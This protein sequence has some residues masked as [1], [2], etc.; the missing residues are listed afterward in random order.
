M[1]NNLVLALYHSPVANIHIPFTCLQKELQNYFCRNCFVP[2]PLKNTPLKNTPFT[3]KDIFLT[4]M[5]HRQACKTAVA[6][7]F[8]SLKIQSGKD[9]L[10]SQAV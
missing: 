9:I 4:Y 7:L 3:T 1:F 6:Y 8:I 5:Q 2:T 10:R